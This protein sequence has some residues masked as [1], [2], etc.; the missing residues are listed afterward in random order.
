[1]KV[2]STAQKSSSNVDPHGSAFRVF[3]DVGHFL[4]SR[5]VIYHDSFFASDISMNCLR[6]CHVIPLSSSEISFLI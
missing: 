4:S 3:C 5:V 6:L 1:M 2:S